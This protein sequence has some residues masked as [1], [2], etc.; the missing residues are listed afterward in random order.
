MDPAKAEEL[1]DILSSG[2]WTHDYP[3][4]VDR[5]RK[6]GL[7]TSTDM[8]PEIYAL[9]DLYPQPAGRRPSVEYVPSSRS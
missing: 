2:H 5:L 3:I 4:T 7:E 6:L 9:M 8:P 1:A